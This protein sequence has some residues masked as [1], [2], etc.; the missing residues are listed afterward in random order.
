MLR[1]RHLSLIGVFFT[2]SLASARVEPTCEN[3]KNP[4]ARTREITCSN[5]NNPDELRASIPRGHSDMKVWLMLENCSMDYLSPGTFVNT[6]A[7][8]LKFKDVQLGSFVEPRSN[9]NP[10]EGLEDTLEAMDFSHNSSLPESWAMLSG[11][12][13]MEELRL[14][15]MARLN[16]TRDYNELPQTMKLMAVVRSTIERVDDDWL[17]S[18]RNL[19]KVAILRSNLVTFSRSMLPRPA[20]KLW[21]LTLE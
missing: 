18:L 14:F 9:Y 10:F 20:P 13:R 1:Q 12:H 3:M 6:S 2:A 5:F 8:I 7:S 11:M 4:V 21:R 17:A 15:K 16:L 19:E